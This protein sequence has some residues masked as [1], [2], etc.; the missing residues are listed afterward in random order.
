MD[1][2]K[3]NPDQTQVFRAQPAGNWSTQALLEGTMEEA[4]CALAEGQRLNPQLTVK[5][6]IDHAP[7]VPQL[8]EGLRKV[9]LP[10]G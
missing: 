7:N 3:C 5:W 8:F 1:S 4:K 9:G 2:P 6:L 10:E